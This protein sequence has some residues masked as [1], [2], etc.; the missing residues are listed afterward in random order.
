MKILTGI[1]CAGVALTILSAC[2]TSTSPTDCATPTLAPPGGSGPGG[3]TITVTINT[4]TVGAYLCYTTDGT[5]PTDGSSP[6]GTVV[7]AQ[8]VQVP[9][10]CVFG[11]TLK[12]QAIAYKPGVC[13]SPVVEGRYVGQ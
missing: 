11:R 13:F 7:K 4:T 1:I 8:T 6:H 10:P 5:T 12:L 2:S 3:S 9:I